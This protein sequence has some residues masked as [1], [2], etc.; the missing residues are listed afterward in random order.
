MLSALDVFA[1]H[2]MVLKVGG[3]AFLE[4]MTTIMRQMS[5]SLEDF[6]MIKLTTTEDINDMLEMFEATNNIDFSD[7]IEDSF[8]NC[9]RG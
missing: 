8:A 1:S 2:D 3:F 7:S 5:L 9:F 6:A 4:M